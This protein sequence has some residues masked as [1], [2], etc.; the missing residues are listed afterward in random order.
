MIQLKTLLEYPYTS[1]KI[2]VKL[3]TEKGKSFDY[4]PIM[5]GDKNPPNKKKALDHAK[6][7]WKQDFEKKYGKIKTAKIYVIFNAD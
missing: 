6:K 1:W 3:K 4:K 5:L 2:H 7:Q